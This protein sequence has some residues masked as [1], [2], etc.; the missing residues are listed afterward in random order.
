MTDKASYFSRAESWALNSRETSARSRRLAW[1]IAGIAAGIAVLETVAFAFLLPLK[2]VQPVTILVDRQTGFVEAVDPARPRTITADD[3][4]T[5][6]L[7]AQYVMAREGFD[8]TTVAVDYRR[9]G[10]WSAGLAR[11]SYLALMPAANPASPLNSP[12]GTVIS[13]NVKSVSRLSQ[14]SAMVRFDTVRQDRSGQYQSTQAWLSVIRY[15]FTDAPMK[16]EDRLINPLG[17]QVLSYRRT[18]EAA[19]VPAA[20]PSTEAP[21]PIA[22]RVPEPMVFVDPQGRR[23]LLRPLPPGT[24]AS[25][26]TTSDDRTDRADR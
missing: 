1:T 6:S 4:L 10:L 17:L 13:V 16:M 19:P 15:R 5:Q 9:V 24:G 25:R 2:T 22:S 11:T 23:L 7:L 18:A 8:R 26:P 12:A 21:V 14:N 3:A 20:V